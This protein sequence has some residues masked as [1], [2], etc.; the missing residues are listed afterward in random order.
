METLQQPRESE[1]VSLNWRLYIPPEHG[2]THLL[3]GV[4]TQK[5][6]KWSTATM[7]T[8]KLVKFNT[9]L[10][11]VNVLSL[12]CTVLAIPEE[13]GVNPSELCYAYIS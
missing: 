3:Q 2:N 7:K 5:K 4:Q 12:N 9:N 13:K 8:L 6:V 1:S 10:C 11:P